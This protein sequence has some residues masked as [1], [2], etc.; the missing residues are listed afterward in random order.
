MMWVCW[1]SSGSSSSLNAASASS[2]WE[3]SSVSQSGFVVKHASICIR[4]NV[5]TQT[6]GEHLLSLN[7][8]MQIPPPFFSVC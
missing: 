8:C 5:I 6:V 3:G 7:T 4:A 1:G 2:V